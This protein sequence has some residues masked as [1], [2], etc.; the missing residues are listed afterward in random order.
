M[1]QSGQLKDVKESQSV[2]ERTVENSIPTS[3]GHLKST[4]E[5]QQEHN[6]STMESETPGDLAMVVESWDALPDHVRKTIFDLISI[7]KR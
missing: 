3:R 6:S 4:T 5:A 2:E 7:Y 1:S